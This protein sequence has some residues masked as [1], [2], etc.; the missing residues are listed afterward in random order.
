LNREEWI[1][2]AILL[3]AIAVIGLAILVF[4]PKGSYENPC[5]TCGS[6]RLVKV[7]EGKVILRNREIRKLIRDAEGRLVAIEIH[8]EV[9]MG[10]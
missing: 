9:K 4:K 1:G 3:G 6:S 7:R 5:P 2:L 8:R 10:D